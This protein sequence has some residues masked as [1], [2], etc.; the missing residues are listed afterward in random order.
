MLADPGAKLT[1]SESAAAFVRDILPGVLASMK[2]EWKW[3]NIPRAVLHDKASYFVNKRSDRHAKTCLQSLPK[4]S[5]ARPETL[6]NQ[7]P[8]QPGEPKR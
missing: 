3:S 4:L 1:N 5:P 6:Q 7:S 8:G 2:K